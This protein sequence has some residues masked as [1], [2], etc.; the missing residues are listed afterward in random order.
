MNFGGHTLSEEQQACLMHASELTA[1]DL[2]LI[3]AGAG[4]SKTFTLNAISQLVYGTMKGIYLAFNNDIVAEVKAVFPAGTD[5]TTTHGLAYRYVGRHYE[6][7]L[8]N[9]MTLKMFIRL[10]NVQAAMGVDAPTIARLAMRTVQ[11]FCVSA[12][13]SLTVHHTSKRGSVAH[14]REQ[15]LFYAKRYWNAMSSS[16][17]TVPVFDDVYLKLFALALQSGSV[18]ISYDFAFLDEAQDSVPVV[19][20][21]FHY[22]RSPRKTAVGDHF[23]SIYQWRYAIN[24]MANF[25]ETRRATLST[26]YRY[27]DNI[28]RLSNAFLKFYQGA[29]TKFKGAGTTHIIHKQNGAALHFDN[30]LVICRTNSSLFELMMEYHHRGHRPTFR[31]QG[32]VPIDLLTEMNSFRKGNNVTHPQLKDFQSFTELQDNIDMGLFGELKPFV[33]V[34]NDYGFDELSN[35]MRVMASRA[36]EDYDV[37]LASAHA[38]KG[39]EANNVVLHSD[40]DRFVHRDSKSIVA[41]SNLVY[42]AM[43]RVKK[44]LDISRCRCL[45]RVYE[46]ISHAATGNVNSKRQKFLEI[47]GERTA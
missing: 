5:V 37:V 32:E 29:N 22:I 14:I 3:E 1:S 21:I 46:D 34:L 18:S 19:R 17:G 8:R 42:V 40:F 25:N 44:N 33:N 15:V 26:S 38:T 12:D 24:A 30:Q 28:A 27:G 7:R 20:Q 6:A 2:L 9:A 41:E 39:I 35:T 45:Q 31:K 23:Q 10:F 4:S 11:A 36:S 13:S 43:T 16:H 47:F